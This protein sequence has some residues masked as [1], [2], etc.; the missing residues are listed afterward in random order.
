M[1]GSEW[2]REVL[3]SLPPL[4]RDIVLLRVIGGLSVEET[5]RIVG[6]RPGAVRTAQHRALARLRETL[7]LKP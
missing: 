3:D 4:Q 7:V 5:A 2:V 1:A 6:R